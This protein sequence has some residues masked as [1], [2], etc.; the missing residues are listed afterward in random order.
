MHARILLGVGAWLLGAIVATGGCLLA[1]SALGQ[2]FAGPSAQQLTASAVQHALA[3]EAADRGQSGATSLV[4]PPRA[5]TSARPSAPRRRPRPPLHATHH[6]PAPPPPSSQPPASKVLGSPGGQVVASC[7]P[8]GAYLVSYSPQQGYDV[9]NVVRGPAAAA[10]VSFQSWS[11]S[12]IMTV[13]CHAGVPS[14]TSSVRRGG[15]E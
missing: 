10:K 2:G 15:D 13:T 11:N 9:S 14:A 1:V 4:T 12:V 6:E 3:T 8:G 7:P 5:P